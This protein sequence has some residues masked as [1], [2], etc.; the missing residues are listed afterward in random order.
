MSST[1]VRTAKLRQKRRRI[2]GDHHGGRPRT[3]GVARSEAAR[4]VPRAPVSREIAAR[5]REAVEWAVLRRRAVWGL[6]ILGTILAVAL[7][8]SV[9]LVRPG[10]RM[11]GV[12]VF[13]LYLL[14]FGMPLYLPAIEQVGEDVRKRLTATDVRRAATREPAAFEHRVVFPRDRSARDRKRS[15]RRPTRHLGGTS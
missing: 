15:G 3:R 12:F 4:P 7:V 13:S 2:A 9:S 6:G 5:R 1:S 11:H 10:V 8:L 14:L